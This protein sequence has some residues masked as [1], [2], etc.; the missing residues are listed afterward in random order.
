M[1]NYT[2]Y[3]LDNGLSVIVHRDITTP[4]VAVN[5]LYHVGAK[6]EHPQKTGLA[7]LFEHLMFGGSENVPKYDEP[8]E[9]VGGE[10]N[11]FTNNDF[12]NYYLS[13]PV[14][15][16]ETAFWLESD[17]MCSLLFSEKKLDIQKNVVIEEYKQ[18]YLNQPYGDVWL[19]LRPMAYKVHP[20]QWPTIGKDPAHIEKLSL[21]DAREFYT[22]FYVPGN[23]ILTVAGNIL[24]DEALRLSE[25]WFGSIPPG[26]TVREKV[27]A[28]PKQ[29]EERSQHLYSNVPANAIYKA[30][31]M[32]RRNDPAYYASDL[33][34]DILGNGR[35]SRFYSELV[36]KQRL[37]SELNAYI[38][39]DLD[40][41]LLVFS[42]K[43]SDGVSMDE[44]ENALSNQV[45]VL[46]NKGVQEKELQKVKNKAE[47]VMAFSQM[48]VLDKAMALSYAALLKN[49]D[50][51]NTEVEKYMQVNTQNIMEQAHAVLQADNCTTLF[52]HA[53]ENS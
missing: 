45:E 9:N 15:N 32:C 6:D 42:G 38:T 27:Q 2:T 49:V 36:Q 29:T 8:L 1:I 44:A 18:R 47:A 13:L 24:P 35:S 31:H 4:L 5:V 39:G 11:A 7:H 14:Q 22:N 51:V 20:Y 28:E 16:V 30:Y 48:R 50:L 21:E 40:E 41:G 26:K 53:K 33:I 43:L 37:F 12:T 34:T 10:N 25:K 52:Y 46:K 23:A 17:R 3:T 19:N